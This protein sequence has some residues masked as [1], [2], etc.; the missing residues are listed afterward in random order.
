M[1]LSQICHEDAE[2]ILL[3]SPRVAAREAYLAMLHAA[4]ARIAA[5]GQKVPATHKGVNMVLGDIYR[6]SGF[7]A[8][9]LLAQVE[10]WKL[11]ADY[12]R[13]AAANA[14]EAREAIELARAFISRMKNDIEPE[15]FRSGIDPAVL[16]ALA[17][18]SRGR[19]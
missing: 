14:E 19:G 13:S 6:G 9:S 3:I 12:G 7:H 18:K 5:N 11:A 17:E 2:Q 10:T 4:H 16:A 8:Q 15:K 1:K